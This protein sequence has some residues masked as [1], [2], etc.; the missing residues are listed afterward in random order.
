K[1]LQVLAHILAL[2]QNS[3]LTAPA[4]VVAPTSLIPNWQAET[5]RFAPSLKLLTLHGPERA[6]RFDRLAGHDVILTSYA[7]LPRDL[8]VLREQ[9]FAFVVLDEAQQ[10][11]NPRTQARRALLSIASHRR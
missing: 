7:L 3:A 1:T 11:K 9:P 8:A 4:L 10:V 5:G 6:R 2:K